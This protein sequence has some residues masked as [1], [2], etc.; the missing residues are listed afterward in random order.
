MCNLH[1]INHPP[2]PSFMYNVQSAFD[3][4]PT[5]TI[6]Y[7]SNHSSTPPRIQPSFT[8]CNLHLI[9]HPPQPS[10]IICKQSIYSVT[11]P[12]ILY[13]MQS[14]FNQPPTSTIVYVSNHSSNPSPIGIFYNM[15]SSFNPPPT[16]T[17]LNNM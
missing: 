4:P 8:T 1:L 9:H 15:Q 10:L 5:S 11:H 7:V 3:Q 17:I 14:A 13:N 6:V 12:T 16:S 2:Q